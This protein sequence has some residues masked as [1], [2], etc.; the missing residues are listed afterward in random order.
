MHMFAMKHLKQLGTPRWRLALVLLC[1]CTA[2]FQSVVSQAHWHPRDGSA[3]RTV[4][5]RSEARATEH[6]KSGDAVIC[7]L[8]QA[9]LHGSVLPGRSLIW[10]P[11]ALEVCEYLAAASVLP[12]FIAAVSHSWR[13]RGPPASAL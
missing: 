3:T 11:G 13:Q 1:L 5:S 8:C 12:L 4:E 9:L 7:P 6:F 2:T 10:T